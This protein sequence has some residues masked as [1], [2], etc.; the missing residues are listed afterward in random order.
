MEAPPQ[1][2]RS[3]QLTVCNLTCRFAEPIRGEYI[4]WI[5]CTHP[6]AINRMKSSTFE[7]E[8]FE[9]VLALRAV[10]SSS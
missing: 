8:R 9:P 1:I 3:P 5:W 10:P 7:C 2:L 6:R 4:G